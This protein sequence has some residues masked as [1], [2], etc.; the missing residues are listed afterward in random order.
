MEKYTR[1]DLIKI[2]ELAIVNEEDWEDRDTERS[3]QNIG[4]CWVLLKAGCD[5]EVTYEKEYK[6]D[7]CVTDEDTIW[8]YIYSKGFMW[9]E[10]AE[11]DDRT[12]KEKIH[13]YLPTM[14]RLAERKGKDWY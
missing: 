5:F 13:I 10:C 2:C 1:E 6:S 7:L 11:D 12:Y 9:F 4:V 14:K 3:Q 8:L